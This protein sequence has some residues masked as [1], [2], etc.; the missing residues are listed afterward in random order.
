MSK[1]SPTPP[2]PTS[3]LTFVEELARRASCPSRTSQAVRQELLHHFEDALA[4]VHDPLAREDRAQ[5]LIAEFGDETILAKL[6]GRAKRRYAKEALMNYSGLIG[7]GLWTVGISAAIALGGRFLI[8]VNVPSV[9]FVFVTA[10]GLSIMTFG[11]SD[12]LTSIYAARVLILNV[13]REDLTA[14][15]AAILR[16]L[17]THAYAGAALGMLA[18]L[19]YMLSG[20]HDPITIGG[21]MAVMIICPLYAVLLSEGILRTAAKRIEHIRNAP[22]D[23]TSPTN[24]QSTETEERLA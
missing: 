5:K 23:E 7:L 21:A 6:I 13:P 16:G 8:F 2:L 24:A 14:H 17:I 12:L 11:A 20:L 10:A 22:P 9:L 3:V 4:E 18:G 1:K 15:N 19:I